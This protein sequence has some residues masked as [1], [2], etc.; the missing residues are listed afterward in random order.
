MS[1]HV[2]KSSVI[3]FILIS[4]LSTTTVCTIEEASTW[5]TVFF[6]D[7]N[8]ADGVL[9]LKWNV[10]PSSNGS[11]TISGNSALY[12]TTGA[13]DNSITAYPDSGMGIASNR[14]TLTAKIITGLN[15]GDIETIGFIVKPSPETGKQ[16]CLTFNKTFFALGTRNSEAD[17]WSWLETMTPNLS[18]NMTYYLELEI[19]GADFTGYIKDS[20]SNIIKKINV[21]GMDYTDWNTYFM[22]MS[23]SSSPAIYFDDYTIKAYY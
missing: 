1:R 10:I 9:G 17:D 20:G 5:H 15:F 23:N 19:D 11:L 3:F 2:L 8:R 13:S 14:F 4:V 16:Y 6:D 18:D 22:L 7:F 12:S 21:K